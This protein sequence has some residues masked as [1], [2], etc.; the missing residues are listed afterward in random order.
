MIETVPSGTVL[1]GRYR[2]ERVLGSGGFGHV[3]LAID[4]STNQQYALKEYLV[5]GPGGQEQLMHEANVLSQLHHPSLPA[6]HDAFN[7]RGHYYVIL[8]YIEGEDL[9]DIIRLT[10]RQNDVIPT[11]QIM[12]WMLTTSDAVLFLH[13]QN[14]PVIHR[15][16]KPDNIRIM[17]N[18]NAILVDLGNAKAYADGSRTLIFIR[19]Q[20]TPGYAPPEQ[21][22]GG[23]GTDARSDVYA[24]GATLYFALVAHEPPSVSTRNQALQQGRPDLP[25]LQE[26]LANNPPE[27][28][29][30]AN[31][32][33]QFRLGVSKPAKPAPRHSRHLA[34]LGK[35]SP[36]V[37]SQLNIIIQRSMAMRPKDRY[38][39]VADF[40]NDLKRVAASLPTF[41]QQSSQQTSPV[42]PN[43]YSTQPDLPMLYEAIQDAKTPASQKMQKDAQNTFH[44]PRCNATIMQN[45]PFCPNCEL[46]LAQ[47]PESSSNIR[48]V[49]N[50]AV[51][52][53]SSS[54]SEYHAGTGQAMTTASQSQQ[55]PRA[56]VP[57]STPPSA[58][59]A[60]ANL[61]DVS[62]WNTARVTPQNPIRA[63]SPAPTQATQQKKQS[64]GFAIGPGLV[65]V[66]LAILI[67]LIILMVV[68]LISHATHATG[69]LPAIAPIFY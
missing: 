54:P 27:N 10:H 7:E 67:I 57:A 32:A 63:S 64:S 14:P 16:I 61:V 51:R 5:S 8:N 68:L 22:P 33:K 29:P 36:L 56:N 43:P 24:L 26:L 42:A 11:A 9:T 69:L 47:S 60:G 65:L 62:T 13:K 55:T 38:Q 48:S 1:N 31:E 20:G 46:P 45:A 28:S 66:V 25:S 12:A 40:A 18:G 4:L 6:F 37:L 50:T 17:P 52:D 30:E 2:I 49:D 3:Y 58:T 15:D 19:H 39:Y 44:C 21:Y 53:K 35:L 59:T 34:Q 41:V 23:S